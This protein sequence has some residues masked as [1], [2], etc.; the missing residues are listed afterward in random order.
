MDFRVSASTYQEQERGLGG[1]C[2]WL[3][4]DFGVDRDQVD[5]SV[6]VVVK[7]RPDINFWELLPLEGTPSYRA[8]V[9]GCVR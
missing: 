5:V 7:R 2:R 6:R 8:Y 1:I 9:K 4:K 3:C